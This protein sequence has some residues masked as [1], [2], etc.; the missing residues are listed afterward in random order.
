MRIPDSVIDEVRSATDIVDLISATVA[1]KKRGKNYVGLCPFHQEKTP[2]FT[3][4]AEKQMYHCFGCSAGGNVFTFVMETEK[5][6]FIEAVRELAERAAIPLPSETRE[7]QAQATEHEGLFAAC[8]TAGLFYYENLVN[9]VEGKLALEY[10]RHRG[11]HDDTIRK[12]GLGYSLNSWD[13]LVRFAEQQHLDLSVMERAGLLARREDGSGYYDRFRGRV[14]FPIFS[15]SGRTV[16]FGARRLRE[17]DPL[18]K[19]I[20]SPETPIYNKSRILYGLSHARD[21]IRSQGYAIL[22]EGYADLLSVFQ[23]GIENIVASS[24]TALTE[25]QI[26]LLARY[27]QSITLVYDGDSAGSKATVRGVDLVLEKGIEVKVA[28]PPAGED[29]DSFVRKE[30]REGF[31]KLLDNAVSFLDFKAKLFQQEGLFSNPEGKSKAVR[32]LVASI[33]KMPDELKRNFYIK[34]VAEKYDIYETVLFRELEQLV[35]RESV[36]RTYERRQVP[37]TTATGQPS[38]KPARE[39]SAADIPAPE[40]DLLRVMLDQGPSMVEYIFSYVNP[41]MFTHPMARRVIALIESRGESEW[42][43]HTLVDGTEDQTLRRFIADVLFSKYELSKGWFGRGTEPEI[44]EPR[45]VADKSIAALRIRGIE[46]LL[47]EQFT[48]L[49]SA[50]GR[51]EQLLPYHQR[52]KQLQQE[53]KELQATRGR[54]RLSAE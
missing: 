24:G 43:H 44:A 40:R 16:G 8:R 28:E 1:L 48:L 23:A 25:E 3:V 17:D 7:D 39:A 31:Q 50:E 30:G 37:G 49:K 47:A 22:V 15:V 21:A 36:R 52:I 45:E 35:G 9:S 34:M 51:G 19:Y 20:N 14:M 10:L 2:S 42:D 12:F 33:A 4:S 26:L 53:R 13:S 38:E 6:S 29:P 46:R 18:G 54:P 27:A 11:F 5:V 41:E 32:S